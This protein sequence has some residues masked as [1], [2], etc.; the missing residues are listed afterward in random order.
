MKQLEIVG[1]KRA[2][3][4][5]ND[6]K[7]IRAEGNVPCVL[8]GGASQVNFHVPVILFRDL[9]GTPDAYEVTLNIEGDEYKAILQDTQFHPVND[10]LL[11]ADFLEIVDGKPLKVEVP[12]R[13]IGTAPG[14]QKGGK[15]IQKLRKLKLKGSA[16]A[17]PDYVDVDVSSLDLGKTIKVAQVELEGVEILDSPANPIASIEIPRSMRGKTAA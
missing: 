2:N 13:F 15:I 12:I 10:M 9:L 3:L 16:D 1:F 4:G 14:V 17:I 11:H 5:K 8:Y 6:A 7:A